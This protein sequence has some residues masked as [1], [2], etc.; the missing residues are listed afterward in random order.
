MSAYGTYAQ[1]QAQKEQADYQAAIMDRNAKVAS[2]QAEDRQRTGQIEEK[3]MRLKNE[4]MIGQAKSDL[5]GSGVQIGTGSTL[6]VVSDQAA[7]SEWDV[8]QHRWD[9]A[10][11][12]WSIKNTASNYSAQSGLYRMAGQNAES[13]GNWGAATSVIS[14]AGTVADKWYTYQKGGGKPI[15]GKSLIG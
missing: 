7:W 3:Q 4:Q 6:D 9:V 10:K 1:G 14:G 13:A 12:I 11:D 8:Q 15:F 5:S 2:M